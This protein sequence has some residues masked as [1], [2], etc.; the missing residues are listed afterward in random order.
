MAD[1]TTKPSGP[2]L[3]LIGADGT[4]DPLMKADG[5]AE[6]ESAAF[7]A[8]DEFQNFYVGGKRDAEVL[9]PP[10]NMKRLER[11]CQ[12]NNTLLPCIEAMVTNIEGTGYTFERIDDTAET[13]EDDTN[14]KKLEDFFK[15][16][17]P[18][19]SFITM[20]KELRNDLERTGNAYIEVLR[21]LAGKVV[22]IRRVDAKMIRLVKLGPAV[23]VEVEVERD[24]VKLSVNVA[25]RERRFVQL[26][27]G[28]EMVYFREFGT[29]RHVN[30]KTGRWED[31]NYKVEPRDRGTELIHLKCQP[32]AHTPYGIPRWIN[33]TPSVLGSRSA[34]EYNLD[35]F[36]HGGIPPVMVFLQGGTM[37]TASRKAFEESLTTGTAA[38]RNRVRIFEVMPTGGTLDKEG[39]ARINVERFGAE[40]QNDAMFESYDD[41]CCTR[42]RRA[43]RLPPI[44]IGHSEDYNYASAEASYKV[45]EAQ[46]FRP[47]RD[48]FDEVISMGLIKELGFPD[49]RLKSNPLVIENSEMKL[50]GIELANTI[51]ASDAEDM[52]HEINDATGTNLKIR[53]NYDPEAELAQNTV[54][55]NGNVVDINAARAQREGEEEKQPVAK[56]DVSIQ[57]L[58]LDTLTALRKRDYRELTKNLQLVNSLDGRGMEEF[59]KAA[60][61]LT[62]VDPTFDADGLADLAGC[63]LHV[64]HAHNH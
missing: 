11:M 10:Y 30:K 43:F 44:F 16:P 23:P 39:Q 5:L 31:D 33:Q 62:F 26:L 40:R 15:E 64:L 36:S 60:A 45:A 6:V 12:E 51:G 57:A 37:E 20:R 34:E 2:Q 47:E 49:Y 27:N 8:E 29:S 38:R 17:W 24:G 46:V 63:T 7:D 52:I 13:D 9:Q 3:R 58:A 4:L 32:D 1:E 41:K 22:F 61:A 50:K 18:R 25:K 59:K 21:N 56:A 55:A 19:K 54:D 48:E 28:K 42:I 14:I 53:D 35:F